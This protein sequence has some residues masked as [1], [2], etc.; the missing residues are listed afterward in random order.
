MDILG[1]YAIV[2]RKFCEAIRWLVN[3]ASLALV[4]AAELL[5]PRLCLELRTAE[6]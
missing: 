3:D 4:S 5:A 2:N 1:N 6:C